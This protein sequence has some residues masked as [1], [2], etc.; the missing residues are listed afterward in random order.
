MVGFSCARVYVDKVAKQKLICEEMLMVIFSYG[1]S[2][3][4]YVPP[5]L[6]ILLWPELEE[7]Q[8]RRHPYQICIRVWIY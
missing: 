1:A 4:V 8:Q 6:N 2:L 7:E 3:T 5:T